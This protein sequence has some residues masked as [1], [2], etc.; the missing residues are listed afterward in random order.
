M[1][2]GMFSAVSGLQSHQKWV[3]VLGNN[4]ANINTAGFKRS[5][6]SFQDILSQTERA[7]G[8]S[9]GDLG[10]TNPQQVGLGARV[11]A[12]DTVFSQGALQSSSKLT[13]LAIQGDG[14]F[15][16]NDGSRD[17]YTRDGAFDLSTTGKLV[18][19]TTGFSVKG[20]QASA[21]GVVDETLPPTT[22][23]IALGVQ[24]GADAD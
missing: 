14:F 23:N 8:A 24:G 22:L 15:I 4:I 3:D 9:S 13:D 10:G 2:R 6:V 18:Q 19:S 16:V 7:A 11:S 12:V 21:A 1:L 17:I 20:W 5:R